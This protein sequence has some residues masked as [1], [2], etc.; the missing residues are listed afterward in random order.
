MHSAAL[1]QYASHTRVA[2]RFAAQLLEGSS[3]FDALTAACHEVASLPRGE[4]QLP[5]AQSTLCKF[6]SFP[7]PLTQEPE[8]PDKGKAKK[9]YSPKGKPSNYHYVYHNGHQV[10][11]GQKVFYDGGEWEIIGGNG[12]GVKSDPQVLIKK[13]TR[14]I[15]VKVSQLKLLP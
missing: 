9:Y 6:L 11:H 4:A 13:G 8:K 10:Q 15:L 2:K 12:G 7:R 1:G 5:Q 3:V 14:S